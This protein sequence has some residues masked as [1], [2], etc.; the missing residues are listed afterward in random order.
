MMEMIDDLKP[1]EE[2]EM[3]YR[4]LTATQRN[5]LEQLIEAAGNRFK[6]RFLIYSRIRS[7]YGPYKFTIAI[8]SAF[9]DRMGPEI[10]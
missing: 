8:L 7:I 10:Q 3:I 1:L 4:S 6:I 9:C 5:E 2:G